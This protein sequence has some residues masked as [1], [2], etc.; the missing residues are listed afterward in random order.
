MIQV[1]ASLLIILLLVYK[2]SS[3]APVQ[4]ICLKLF[5]DTLA[6]I[7]LFFEK[8]PAPPYL[9]SLALIS[10]IMGTLF[11]LVLSLSAAGRASNFEMKERHGPP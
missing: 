7:L 2:T 5:F 1:L 9:R 8:E 3:R 4:L 6:A 11:V 10:I